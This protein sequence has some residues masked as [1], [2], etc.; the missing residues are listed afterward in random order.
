MGGRR[1]SLPR[2]GVSACLLGQGVRFDGGHKRDPFVTDV[3]A[4]HFTL[5]P[6][7][8]EMESGLGVPRESMRLERSAGGVRLVAPRSGSDHT[9]RLRDWART[10]LDALETAGLSGFVLKKDSPSCGL[11][12]VRVYGAAGGAT[13]DGRGLFAQALADRFPLLPLEEEGRLHDQPL[14]E[15]FVTRVLAYARLQSLFAGRWTRGQLVR[16]H[17]VEKL[18]LL[19]HSPAAYRALGRLVATS[20]RMPRAEVRQRYAAG[21]MEA[22]AAPASAGRVMNALQHV[23]GYFKRTL[24][25]GERR[26]LAHLIDEHR[27]GRLPLVAPLLLLLHHARSRKIDSLDRQTFLDAGPFDL[28][29]RR[30][31]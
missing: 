15:S 20:A 23:A 7:C 3:L 5:V 6:V 18:L 27:R 25:D 4:R 16:F 30:H 29:P 22:L 28:Q 31:S 24:P 14:R 19:A 21:F 12:R 11:E 8:P 17:T 10:R 26:E 13:R 9:E 1:V 2:L